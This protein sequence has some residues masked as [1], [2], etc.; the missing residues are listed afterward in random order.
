LAV[1]GDASC[2]I[3]SPPKAASVKK[4]TV[5]AICIPRDRCI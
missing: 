1:S 5:V 4:R 2:A 3:A